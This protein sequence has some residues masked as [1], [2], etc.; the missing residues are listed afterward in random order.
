MGCFYTV[1]GYNRHVVAIDP[2]TGENRLV[3]PR[4]QDAAR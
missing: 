4:A 1:A 2:K 3:L